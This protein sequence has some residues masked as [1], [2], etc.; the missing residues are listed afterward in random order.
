[1]LPNERL[2]EPAEIRKPIGYEREYAFRRERVTVLDHRKSLAK[3]ALVVPVRRAP[4]AGCNERGKDWA[5]A[6]VDPVDG[7]DR[8]EV[9]ADVKLHGRQRFWSG[10]GETL[11][12]PSGADR[13]ERSHC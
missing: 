12:H 11:R 1:M 13:S 10:M 4:Q 3:H 6:E 5:K 9:V 8:A 7:F 2:G